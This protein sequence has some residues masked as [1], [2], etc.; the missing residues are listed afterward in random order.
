M[1]K[2]VQMYT[3]IQNTEIFITPYNLK[4]YLHHLY[5]CTILHLSPFF[6]FNYKSKLSVPE[7][8]KSDKR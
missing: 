4:N 8:L 2:C 7:M 1:Y 6:C 5:N 3:H